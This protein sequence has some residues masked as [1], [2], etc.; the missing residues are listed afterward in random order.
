MTLQDVR[1]IVRDAL[2]AGIRELDSHGNAGIAY[3][4]LRWR[5]DALER[6]MTDAIRASE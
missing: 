6:K 1:K 3:E 4:E 2:M 5:I